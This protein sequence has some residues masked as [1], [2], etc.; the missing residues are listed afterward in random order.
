M[1]RKVS[2]EEKDYLY[3]RR[4]FFIFYLILWGYWSVVVYRTSRAVSTAPDRAKDFRG[5]DCDKLL[6]F[7]KKI[8]L[9]NFPSN[10]VEYLFTTARLATQGN[11]A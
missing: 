1:Q 5:S 8:I 3:Y 4:L 9:F 2:A 10:K 7:L 6:I 11:R